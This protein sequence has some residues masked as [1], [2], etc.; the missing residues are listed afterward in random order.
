M[1]EIKNVENGVTTK[2]KGVW[3]ATICVEEE[4]TNDNFT[5]KDLHD[6]VN[7][8]GKYSEEELQ[9]AVEKILSESLGGNKIS[10]TDFNYNF[11]EIET[12]KNNK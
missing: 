12:S 7:R 9:K 5:E 8:C 1:S 3:N 11:K 2:Y 10:V 4:F 6:F